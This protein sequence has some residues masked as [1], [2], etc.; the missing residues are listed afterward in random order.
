[1]AGQ[2]LNAVSDLFAT[3]RIVDVVLALTVAEWLVLVAYRRR[4]GRGLEA[5]DL[6]SNLLAG[7]FLL[8][9]LRGALVNAWWGWIALLLVAAFL[10]HVSDLRRRWK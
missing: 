3:G 5:F 9:A 8:L 6:L 7:I 4:T 2:G 10:A 1:L